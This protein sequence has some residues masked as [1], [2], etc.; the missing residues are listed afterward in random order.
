MDWSAWF[1]GKGKGH[2]KENRALV[3][4]L[5]EL[6]VTKG[7]TQGELAEALRKPQSYV[8]KIERGERLMDPVEFRQIVEALGQ[9]VTN[10]VRL[11][12]T[13]TPH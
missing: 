2:A 1:V 5:K 8:S 4:I 3:G 13:R 6:R 7:F 11:W 9:D 12:V 10:V